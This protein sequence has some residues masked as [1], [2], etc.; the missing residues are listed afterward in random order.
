ME[1]GAFEHWSL[2]R[3]LLSTLISQLGTGSEGEMIG[4]GPRK[5]FPTP[6]LPNPRK[7]VAPSIQH[8]F[9]VIGVSC[10]SKIPPSFSSN[11]SCDVASLMTT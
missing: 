1:R 2:Q 3:S 4:L 7:V 9:S 5:L 11:C 10:N 6:A 8:S